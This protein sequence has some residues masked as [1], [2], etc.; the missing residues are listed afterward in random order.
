MNKETGAEIFAKIKTV[1]IRTNLAALWE[2]DTKVIEKIYTNKNILKGIKTQEDFQKGR[3]F[4]S[5]YL[6]KINKN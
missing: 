3:D 1:Y 5:G 4:Q 6:D 2:E